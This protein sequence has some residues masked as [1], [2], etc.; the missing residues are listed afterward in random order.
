MTAATFAAGD[1]AG[2]YS[3][4]CGLGGVGGGGVSS[5]GGDEKE[6]CL[7]VVTGV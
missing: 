1:C 5:L 3:W 7:L 4:D 2:E 6:T